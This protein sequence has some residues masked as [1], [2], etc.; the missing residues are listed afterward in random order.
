M[1]RALHPLFLGPECVQFIFN[2]LVYRQINSATFASAVDRESHPVEALFQNLDTH[3]DVRL[4][5]ESCSMAMSH[6]APNWV[7]YRP[8]NAAFVSVEK[9]AIDPIAQSVAMARKY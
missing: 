1:A 5:V 8:F 4:L 6:V 7:T 3:L 2:A 9:G